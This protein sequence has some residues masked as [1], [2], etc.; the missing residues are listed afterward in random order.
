L[1]FLAFSGLI[2]LITLIF[3]G[4]GFD[5]KGGQFFIGQWRLW[6]KA[7]LTKKFMRIIIFLKTYTSGMVDGWR[8]DPDW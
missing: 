3:L 6:R 2:I 7:G 5:Q 4:L 8:E 1:F